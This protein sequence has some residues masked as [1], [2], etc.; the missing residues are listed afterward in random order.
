MI[1]ILF[2]FLITT[3]FDVDP[4]YNGIAYS[5]TPGLFK[6]DPIEL[7]LNLLQSFLSLLLKALFCR[8]NA[9]PK[10]VVSHHSV[11]DL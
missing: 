9:E 10:H 6:F 3:L 8:A 11:L 2:Y 7:Q 1:L 5:Q 4:V